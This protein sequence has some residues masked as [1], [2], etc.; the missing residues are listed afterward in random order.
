MKLREWGWI[1]NEDD[2]FFE[3]LRGMEVRKKEDE[4]S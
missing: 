1:F 2:E 3:N 4:L